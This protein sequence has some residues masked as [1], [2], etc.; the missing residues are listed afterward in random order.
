L[1]EIPIG[2][3]LKKTFAM[4]NME[5]VFF[6]ERMTRNPKGPWDSCPRKRA[7]RY[8][9]KRSHCFYADSLRNFHITT[10]GSRKA[11]D[12]TEINLSTGGKP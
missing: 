10:Y 11:I 12:K 7:G 4:A 6:G 3:V 1:V 5:I 9:L 8:P 2:L